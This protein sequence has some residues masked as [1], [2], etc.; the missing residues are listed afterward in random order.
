MLKTETNLIHLLSQIQWI[1]PS[2]AR[3]LFL[4]I[5]PGLPKKATGNQERAVD[6]VS[7]Y[8]T[9]INVKNRN[10]SDP[11]AI[12]NSVDSSQ[13]GSVPVSNNISRATEKSN[14][15]SRKGG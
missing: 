15:E 7:I 13:W 14:R 3:F 11:P 10:Q 6:L 8:I 5:Y 1:A 12:S 2:G 4:I 9:K